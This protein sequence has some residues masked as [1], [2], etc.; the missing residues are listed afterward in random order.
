MPQ[1]ALS[2]SRRYKMASQRTSTANLHTKI[3]D[4]R[5]LDSSIF[6][7]LRGGILMSIWSSPEIM[8]R[9]ILVRKILVWTYLPYSSPLSNRLGAVSFCFYRLRRETSISQNWLKGYNM[10]TMREIGRML[11]ESYH[12]GLVVTP[13]LFHNIRSP[14]DARRCDVREVV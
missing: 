8:S 5:G 1:L 9:H 11:I 12:V 2:R 4:F 10:A 13:V 7:I 3:L 14:S 6:L